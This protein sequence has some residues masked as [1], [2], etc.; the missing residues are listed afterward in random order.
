MMKKLL[1]LLVLMSMSGATLFAQSSISQPCA[2]DEMAAQAMLNDPTIATRR[3]NVQSAMAHIPE[4]YEKGICGVDFTLV[5]LVVHILGTGATSPISM[6]QVLSQF[7]VVNEDYMGNNADICAFPEADFAPN[8]IAWDGA[9]LQFCL[10]DQNHPTGTTTIGGAFGTSAVTYTQ[11]SS[12]ESTQIANGTDPADIAGV[13]NWGSWDATTGHNQEYINVWVV[14]SLSN[15]PGESVLGY[16]YLPGTAP[17]TAGSP[18][19]FNDGIVLIHCAFGTTGTVTSAGCGFGN[20]TD[21]GRTLTHELGHY[22][23][24]NHPFCQP[25]GCMCDDSEFAAPFNILDTPTQMDAFFGCPTTTNSCVDTPDYPDLYMNFMQYVDD[26]CMYMFT[27]DQT[28]VINAVATFTTQR[29]ALVNNAPLVCSTGAPTNASIDMACTHCQN[30]VMDADETG[31]DCGGADCA[32]CSTC[33]ID[34]TN[35]DGNF[36]NANTGMDWTM[37]SMA[38][39]DPLCSEAICGFP[40]PAGWG[41]FYIW[42]GGTPGPETGFISQMVT[43][44]VGSVALEFDLLVGCDDVSEDNDFVRLVVDGVTEWEWTCLD[45]AAPPT[46]S[47]ILSAYAD[48]NPHEIRFESEIMAGS[49]GSNFFVDNIEL[50]VNDACAPSATFE[51]VEC[52]PGG[53]ANGYF[54]NT[55]LVDFGSGTS[56][57]NFTATPAG[58]ASPSLSLAASVWA[59][60]VALGPFD[61]ESMVQITLTND[62]DPNCATTSFEITGNCRPCNAD[63]GT[64][65]ANATT[66]CS[67]EDLVLQSTGGVMFSENMT[68]TN[69]GLAY[70]FYSAPPTNTDNPFEDPAFEAAFLTQENIAPHVYTLT[71]TFPNDTCLWVTPLTVEDH[72]GGFVGACYGF[73]ISIAQKITFLDR[74]AVMNDADGDNLLDIS[75][76]YTDPAAPNIVFD[77]TFSDTDPGSTSFNVTSTDATVLNGTGI[78]QGSIFSFSVSQADIDLALADTTLAFTVTATNGEMCETTINLF[79]AYGIFNIDDFCEPCLLDAGI[80]VQLVDNMIDVGESFDLETDGAIVEPG[81][82]VIGWGVSLSDQ[83]AGMNAPSVDG[84]PVELPAEICSFVDTPSPNPFDAISVTN[85]NQFCDGASGN[86]YFYPITMLDV[87][88]STSVTTGSTTPMP[89]PDGQPGG[90]LG[91]PLLIPLNIPDCV[92]QQGIEKIC[93]VIE[94]E[95]VGD[96]VILLENPTTGTLIP[97]TFEN[98]G[99]SAHY[100][101]P[102]P[103]GQEACFV[104][105][106]AIPAPGDITAGCNGGDPPCFVGNF[107]P[108]AGENI[109]SDGNPLA[110]FDG[111]DLCN[112]QLIIFDTFEGDLGTVLSWN[113]TTTQ[114]TAIPFPAIN[115]LCYKIGDPICVNFAAANVG[116]VGNFRAFL[117]G[118]YNEATDAMTTNLTTDGLIPLEQPY[119]RPPWM[120]LG[121]ESVAT[122]GDIPPTVTDWILVEIREDIVDCPIVEQRAAWLLSNGDIVD[123]NGTGGITFANLVEGGNYLV[124]IRHRNHLA[125]LSATAQTVT[126]G[127]FAYDFTIGV[128]QAQGTDQMVEKGGISALYAGDFDSNGTVTVA[129]FNFYQV[130]AALLNMYLDGDVNMDKSV[131]VADFNFYQPNASIIGITKIRY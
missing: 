124:A 67:G 107:L 80:P 123:V 69:P 49:T 55:T 25:A 38:F 118:P 37:F 99:A 130:Q 77:F 79:A 26:D 115:T 42:F 50:C 14:P 88:G 39:G 101:N 94:H 46:I 112:L 44:P 114:E 98:G 83:L 20:P 78:A 15:I 64:F 7:T 22:F 2:T 92:N 4:D 81:I 56:S 127:A 41:T 57:T 129:D 21:G 58:T 6:A 100:G 86:L 8:T 105:S 74:I 62:D 103:G 52:P 63:A 125:V 43:I 18:G 51:V 9:C 96:I 53:D 59:T 40:A 30:G 102:V 120:Y 109:F 72:S 82:G 65:S 54:I 126:G 70:V 28:D 128:A 34:A 16:A 116:V 1:L 36:E 95:F 3:A 35:G 5:P 60:G 27:V 93:F 24:L 84:L 71:N 121:T 119:A 91:D 108:E 47:V 45:G 68:A 87:P 76:D 122:A 97:L 32:P 131:T 104:R 117:E 19:E 13:P 48:G 75:C 11:I 23:G 113:V 66:I 61:N 17:Q 73:D 33:L 106:S 29:G 10:P 12:A 85:N 110:L 90:G 111:E 89:I 31:I